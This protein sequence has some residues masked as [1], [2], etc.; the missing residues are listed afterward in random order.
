MDA[1]R[2]WLACAERLT[3]DAAEGSPL[4]PVSRLRPA[5][6]AGP[7]ALCRWI[8]RGKRGVYLDGVRGPGKSWC[9]T[10][11]AVARFFAQLSAVEAGRSPPV[12]PPAG[13]ARR[14]R[15]AIEELRRLGVR[16]PV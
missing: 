12:E 1:D 5:A 11:L 4:V 6:G 15:A 10:A 9:S 13:R 8:L 2:D 3:R 16:V 14:A 7:T